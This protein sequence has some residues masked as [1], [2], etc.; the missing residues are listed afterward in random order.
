MN[1]EEGSRSPSSAEAEI[2]DRLL[3]ADFPGKDQI[4]DQL[5][6]YRVRT[7]DDDGSLELRVTSAAPA[8]NVEKRIPGEAQA[9]D[10]DGIHVHFLLHV[11]NGFAAE[12]EIYKDDGTPIARL[13]RADEL[14]VMVLGR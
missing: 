3:A 2:I 7:I 4:A 9:S 14:E 11:V 12:L 10:V 1:I 5:R 6:N 13:P 8:A